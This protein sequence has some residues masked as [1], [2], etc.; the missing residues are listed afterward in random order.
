MEE[1]ASKKNKS[2]YIEHNSFEQDIKELND[3]F[4]NKSCHNFDFKFEPENITEKQS[5]NTFVNKCFEQAELEDINDVINEINKAITIN[6]KEEN[7]NYYNKRRHSYSA[8]NISISKDNTKECKEILSILKKPVSNKNIRNLNIFD[9]P[10]KALLEPKK[11][12][13]E[14]K[15]FFSIP[16]GEENTDC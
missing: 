15:I 11:L 16:S 5:S 6:I 14:G 13:L 10:F 12:F 4:Q 7:F 8:Q 1:Y 3:N 2:Q 9:C